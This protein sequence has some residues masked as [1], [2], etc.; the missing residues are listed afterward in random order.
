MRP[1]SIF[2]IASLCAVA[3]CNKPAE[4]SPT[5]AANVEGA[6]SP[7]SDEPTADPAPTPSTAPTYASHEF[8]FTIEDPGDERLK[9]LARIADAAVGS[10]SDPDPDTKKCRAIVFHDTDDG[11]LAGA[12]Y[13]LRVREKLDNKECKEATN[14][15]EWDAAWKWRGEPT[16]A[17][18]VRSAQGGSPPS[19]ERDASW[20][21]GGLEGERA[22]FTYKRKDDAPVPSPEQMRP[23]ASEAIRGLLGDSKLS[24]RCKAPVY[25][26]K[27]ELEYEGAAIK[28]IDISGWSYD[29]TG[30][31]GVLEVSFKIEDPAA[32]QALAEKLHAGLKEAG[33]LLPS[34]SKSDWAKENCP[35]P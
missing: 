15:E 29:E 34:K 31:L 25:E 12:G 24:P 2:V 35:K 26:H 7:D 30:P 28:D 33:L 22:A 23:F 18:G 14:T 16:D 6:E 4:S 10:K 1:P 9:T 32:G 11:K 27:W 20:G 8:K 3:S 19:L 13:S 21:V 17:E 5:V